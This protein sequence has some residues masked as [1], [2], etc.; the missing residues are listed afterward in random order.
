MEV[1]LTTIEFKMTNKT[2]LTHSIYIYLS[3][4]IHILLTQ[5]NKTFHGK[6]AKDFEFHL[7]M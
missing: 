6:K 2:I 1:Q 3:N 7:L 4:I 5:A